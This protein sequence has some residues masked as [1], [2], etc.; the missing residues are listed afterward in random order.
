M[1]ISGAISAGLGG[2]NDLFM[3]LLIAQLQ[4]QNPMEPMSNSEMVTQMTQLAALDGINRL[5]SSFQDILGLYRLVGG[6]GL[7]GKEIEYQDDGYTGR[8]VVESVSMA[9]DTIKL[10]VNGTEISLDQVK[11][12]L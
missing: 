3:K 7:L 11:A 1:E 9:G 5:N 8:G 10:T 2:T 6:T 4:N 12:I